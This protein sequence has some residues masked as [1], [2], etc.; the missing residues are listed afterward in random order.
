MSSLYTVVA[1]PATDHSGW[2]L[3]MIDKVTQTLIDALKEALAEP[4]EQRLFRTG[5]L[6]GLF[7]GRTGTNAEAAERALREG[8]LEVVRTE[9]KGKTATEWVRL[10]PR[11][12]EFLHHHES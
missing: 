11:A 1:L 5:K 12:M 8:L 2:I 10:T 6:E 7:A 4:G 3:T 9:T